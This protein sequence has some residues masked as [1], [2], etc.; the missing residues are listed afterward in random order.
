M[1]WFWLGMAVGA[2]VELLGRMGQMG[3]D[4]PSEESAPVSLSN[5]T[6]FKTLAGFGLIE[7]L[8]GRKK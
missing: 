7:W 1:I 2:G 8:F 4:E 6:I 5:G 3:E